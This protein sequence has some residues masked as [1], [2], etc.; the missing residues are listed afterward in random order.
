[1]NIRSGVASCRLWRPAD[2][3]FLSVFVLPSFR[4]RTP[5]RVSRGGFYAVVGKVLFGMRQ[6]TLPSSE[7]ARS[8][9]ASTANSI[10]S[11]LMTSLA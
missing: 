4:S 9:W 6:P 5:L 3:A 11:L 7:M 8:F 2:D 10:G 1:M